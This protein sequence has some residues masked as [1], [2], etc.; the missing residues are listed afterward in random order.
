MPL[1]DVEIRKAKPA[2]KPLKLTDGGGLYLI[3]RPNGAKWW[4]MDYS[5]GGKRKTLSMGVYPETTLKEAREKLESAKALIKSG[6]DP[7]QARREEKIALSHD[8]FGAVAEDWLARFRSSW[9]ESHLERTEMILRNDILPWIKDRPIKEIMAPEVL[10]LMRRVEDRGALNTAHR[11]RCIAGQVFRY[12]IATGKADR[13]PSGDLRG[14]LPQAVE[15]HFAAP[16]DP[17]KAGEILRSIEAFKG[18]YIVKS[19]LRLSPLLFCRPGELRN[20]KWSEID[21]DAGEWR[22]TVSK[23]KTPHL[24]PLSTQ[25]IAI[26]RDLK[27]LTCRHAHVFPGRDP[28]KPLSET[29]INAALQRMGYDTKTDITGHGFRAMARTLLHERLGFAPEV[30]EHQ[31]AH[32]VPGS[33]GSAYNRTKFID[34][35]KRMMQVWAD[36][37]DE[38]KAGCPKKSDR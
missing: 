9:S 28:K 13:D 7:S 31:L 21:L 35:R 30:I 29:T 27:P 5:F 24:V 3:L 33:L 4:R 38:L 37:L 11:V 2:E 1:T 23:T 25:A 34:E 20:A 16:T 32:K 12:A 18:N 22:Y 36:Y 14:A 10:S 19:A 17:D 8:T 15:T 6:Y 26:L